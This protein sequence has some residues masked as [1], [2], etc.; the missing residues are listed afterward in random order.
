MRPPRPPSDFRIALGLVVFL[1]MMTLAMV[2]AAPFV[3]HR[4]LEPVDVSAMRSELFDLNLSYNNALH[5]SEDWFRGEGDVLLL[6]EQAR[7]LLHRTNVFLARPGVGDVLPDNAAPLHET[8]RLL[9]ARL[10]DA[11]SADRTLTTAG[12][13]RVADAITMRS[14]P[15]LRYVSEAFHRLGAVAAQERTRI[16]NARQ[17]V[18]WLSGLLL[19][20]MALAATILMLQRR[21][22]KRTGTSLQTT[23]QELSDAHRIARIG[24]FRWNFVRDEVRWSDRLADIFGLEP[25]GRMTGAEFEAL[26]HPEDLTKVR[27]SERQAT[28]RATE[29]GRPAQREISYRL[30]RPDG[31]I[32]D[33]HAI[34]EITS[35]E[36][37]R[38]V[39]MT[40]TVRDVTEE[41][42]RRRALAESERSLAEAQRIAGLGSFRRNVATGE[43]VWS[44]EMYR[45]VGVE[46]GTT[47][48]HVDTIIHPDDLPQLKADLNVLN[49]DGPPGGRR[50]TSIRC[51]MLH[52]DGSLRF[53][54]GAA[55][56]SYDDVGRPVT[57]TGTLRDMTTEVAQQEAIT[58]AAEE[59]RRANA[60]KSD[61][62]AVMSHELRTPMN[63]VLG[64]LSVLSDT[65]LNAEQRGQLAIARSSAEALLAIL[66]DILD[67]SKIEAGRMEL[68]RAPFDLPLLIEAVV[69]LYTP[70]AQA[71]GLALRHEI[72]VGVPTW[73]EGDPGRLRQILLN[74][75]SNAVK[76][77]AQGSVTL[78]VAV[79]EGGDPVRLVFRVRDTGMGIPA[80]RQPLVFERFNQLDATYNRKFGGTGLGLAISRN[81]TERMGGT[82]RFSSIEGEG[83]EFVIE[84]AFPLAQPEVK[85]DATVPRA[86]RP[87]DILVAED[88]ATNQIVV[89]T[90]LERL[91]HRVSIVDNGRKAVEAADRQAYDLVLMDLSMP[92]MDGLEATRRIRAGR[93]PSRA[94]PI[95]ALTAHAGPDEGDRC[96]EAG[97]DGLLSKPIRRQTLEE[98][99]AP[100]AGGT[101]AEAAPVTFRLDDLRAEFSDEELS[102]LIEVALSD[103]G[104]HADTLADPQAPD[105]DIARACHSISGL[106][107]TF[108]AKDLGSA[109]SVLERQLRADGPAGHRD[110]LRTLHADLMQVMRALRELNT[111]GG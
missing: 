91:G 46:P 79:A 5:A 92:E 18:Q 94:V 13:S 87:L 99:L 74:L 101:P 82:I 31:R 97:L 26:V 70:Q 30:R 22:L 10:E 49:E 77:T 44:R 57:L 29:S 81:L 89:R 93:G 36:E 12:A 105:A 52:R 4:E 8:A 85:E 7:Q 56:M 37:N 73:V 84:M 63:G 96:R 11:S 53:V 21:R 106:A 102:G 34:S 6:G 27:E 80:E 42:A 86:A 62:L 3:L 60:A 55:E 19:A 83:T 17:A 32:V 65:P 109:A 48:P 25:G 64:M 69:A 33:V 88:N 67:M 95:L 75:V 66:N 78:S 54:H 15:Y 47:P 20:I 1:V 38:P 9:R 41:M 61:F 72:A 50:P 71:K 16:D 35:D 103:L 68:E 110:A 90:M 104:R 58:R 98:A 28:Q 100:Y 51:R 107:R 108:G 76:F 45:M 43:I 39:F 24:S 14:G 23:A 111:T 59:A 2:L 40:S